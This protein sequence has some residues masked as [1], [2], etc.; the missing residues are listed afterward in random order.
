MATASMLLLEA[1][2]ELVSRNE[3]PVGLRHA[4][5]AGDRQNPGFQDATGR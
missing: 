3:R 2:P 1:N 4:T 5:A